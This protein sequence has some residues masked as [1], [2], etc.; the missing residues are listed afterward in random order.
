MPFTAKEGALALRVV[1]GS[2]L[3]HVHAAVLAG[4][5][6]HR[7]LDVSSSADGGVSWSPRRRLVNINAWFFD[8]DDLI[9]LVVSTSGQRAIV[10]WFE[11]TGEP[12]PQ[13]GFAGVLRTAATE[14]AGATWSAPQQVSRS[15]IS[16]YSAKLAASA[17][18][19][20]VTAVAGGFF[21]A[22]GYRSET[23]TSLDGGLSWPRR[24]TLRYAKKIASTANG[25]VLVAAWVGGDQNAMQVFVSRSTDRGLTWSAEQAVSVV[26]LVI[27]QLQLA[28]SADGSTVALLWTQ[29]LSFTDVSLQVARSRDRGATWSGIIQ[30][31]DDGCQECALGVSSDGNRLSAVWLDYSG[32]TQR[33]RS[34]SSLGA[35]LAWTGP[36]ALSASGGSIRDLQLGISPDGQRVHALWGRDNGSHR[37]A[38]L[39]SS[40]SAGTAWL[41]A[42]DLSAVEALAFSPRVA[43]SG[44]ASRALVL[45]EG[46]LEEENQLRV[47]GTANGGETWTLSQQLVFGP[48]YAGVDMSADGSVG[49]VIR[50]NRVDDA[51]EVAIERSIDGGA[52][53]EAP[54]RL[55][56]ESLY[57]TRPLVRLSADGMRALAV[58]VSSDDD[59][60]RLLAS[61]SEDAGVSW[62]VPVQTLARSGLADS[63]QLELSDNGSRALLVTRFSGQGRSRLI[64]ARSMDGGATWGAETVL[65]TADGSAQ[66]PELRASGDGTNAVIAWIQSRATNPYPVHVTRSAD[67]GLSWSAPTQ[68]GEAGSMNDEVQLAGGASG[69][70]NVLWNTFDGLRSARSEDGGANWGVPFSP[71]RRSST[72]ST[73]ARLESSED[74]SNLTLVWI[75][76]AASWSRVTT[77]SSTTAGAVWSVPRAVS[78]GDGF[79][80]SSRL[81]LSATGARALVVWRASAGGSDHI[82]AA[83][84]AGLDVPVFED[85]FESR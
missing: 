61:R 54:V 4:R 75:D 42:S 10:S 62:T 71:V 27:A 1:A 60:R 56:N 6:D 22:Q 57:S 58:W 37:S 43:M 30:I 35:G 63:A 79:V 80:S 39:A 36:I 67:A 47:S 3:T 41:Q 44:D 50:S 24:A 85:G 17:D 78:S 29:A 40:G 19:S 33:V 28:L 14:D 49:L 46:F 38:Q 7:W 70:W 69:I 16:A 11:S 23:A 73:R 45:W 77:A 21:D 72:F 18:L 31:A 74:G 34:S 55:S 53:W 12:L 9:D 59:G 68:L 64:A 2:D 20:Q 52:S 81:A 51:I 5:D 25:S 66:Q 48:S 65:S 82:Q 32:E 8:S 76:S 15:G 84:G 26:S 13:G 83:S